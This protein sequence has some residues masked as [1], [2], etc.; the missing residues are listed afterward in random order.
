MLL[1]S[2]SSKIVLKIL[3]KYQEFLLHVRVFE[4]WTSHVSSHK[5]SQANSEEGLYD[6]HIAH[7]NESDFQ[8]GNMSSRDT[9]E[10]GE[11]KG[12]RFLD[13]LI[14]H[15]AK[16]A[17]YLL[18]ISPLY[19]SDSNDLDSGIHVRSLIVYSKFDLNLLP[20]NTH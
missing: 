19:Q 8:V 7:T 14:D 13:S 6:E 1:L 11:S 15:I 4:E 18:S 17:S 3:Q 9:T 10:N 20:G 2:H 16:K 5:Q 12:K